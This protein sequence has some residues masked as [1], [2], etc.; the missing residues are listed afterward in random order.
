MKAGTNNANMKPNETRSSR[1]TCADCAVDIDKLL[2]EIE[3]AESSTDKSDHLVF[4]VSRLGMGTP[5]STSETSEN[6]TNGTEQSQD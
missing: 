4:D 3:D 5:N 1:L 2:A 6:A